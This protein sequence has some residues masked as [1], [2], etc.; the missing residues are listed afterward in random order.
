MA[1][2][3]VGRPV[4]F[5]L[6]L[7]HKSLMDAVPDEVAGR[8][9][10]A[11]LRYFDTG[12]TVELDSLAGAVFAA[13]KPHIDEA[14][15]DF[16]ETSEKNRRNAKVRWENRCMPSDATGNHSLPNDAKNAEEEGEEGEGEE[17]KEGDM[18]D[19]PPKPAHISPPSV[20]A[21]REYC[22]KQGYT[23]IDPIRFVNYYAARNWMSGKTAITDWRAALE[24][25]LRT[26]YWTKWNPTFLF[27]IPLDLVRQE[28]ALFVY[29]GTKP[30][31]NQYAA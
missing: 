23:A 6:F 15:E 5:K 8:A 18:V 13:L 2:N 29:P 26:F 11:A 30:Y 12:E 17:E 16:Q 10:K 25:G 21:V 27:Y 7:H 22:A 31:T 19:K 28:T 14:F 9:V 1:R 4:W 24:L 20:D 3:K